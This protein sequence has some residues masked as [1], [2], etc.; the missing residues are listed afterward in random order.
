MNIF[1]SGQRAIL[2][3]I[4]SSRASIEFD[5][6]GTILTVNQVFVDLFGYPA[7]ELQGQH[8]RVLLVPGDRDTPSYHEFWASL[9]RGHS[10]TQSSKCMTRDG[11]EIWVHA[12]YNAVLRRNGSLAKVVT[13][14]SDI[15]AATMRTLE[16][17][18]QTAA[19]DR[20]QAVI[21]F[22]PDGYILDANA[23][24][25]AAVGYG[26]EEIRG[27]HHSLLVDPTV[28]A[29][30]AYAGFWPALARGDFQAGEFRRIGKG[31]REVWL[32]ATY[33]PIS[34][35]DGRPFKVIKF[36]TDV[37]TQ[38][39]DRQRRA[40]LQH[41][42]DRDLGDI[43]KAIGNVSCQTERA[44]TTVKRVSSEIQSVAS[45]AEELSASVGEI[46]QQVTLAARIAGEAVDQARHTGTIV[47]GLSGQAAQI[48]DVVGLIQGIAAQTNLLALNATIEAARAGPAGRGFAVVA[49]EV[50]ALAEQT[51]RA[52]EQIGGQIAATQGAT[53]EAV[54]AINA[55]QGTIQ[56]LNQVSSAIAA[57]VEEQSAVTREMSSSMQMASQ[58]A[59]T[60]AIDMTAIAQAS[61]QVDCGTRQVREAS[62][63]LA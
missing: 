45:G 43:S 5:P 16:L 44:A 34:G 17:E 3:A 20:S 32:Q 36:A 12:I 30:D 21:A 55:I 23:N 59:S 52:T 62:H 6:D 40:A 58:G 25:L 46:S 54:S 50:K 38:V 63:R 2:R 24:F 35:A 53:R 10:Q 1:G 61:T 26:V 27:Q 9:R 57:A 31:G 18:A 8:H 13:F 42:I 39:Q 49:A 19:L 11:R 56:T 15:T 37:T 28:K 7:T 48:G 51:A 22:T 41:K 29:S 47:A 4:N 14:A 33:T 60:L